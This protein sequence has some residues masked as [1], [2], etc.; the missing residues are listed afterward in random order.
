[1]KL[2]FTR[3]AKDDLESIAAYIQQQ[4][5]EAALRVRD[6]IIDSLVPLSFSHA[7]GE[8]RRFRVSGKS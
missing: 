7:S 3:Q 4:N 8:G 5:P 1:M 6:A 2:Y